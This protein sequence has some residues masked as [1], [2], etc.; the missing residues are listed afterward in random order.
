MRAGAVQLNSTDDAGA[1]LRAAETG[2]GPAAL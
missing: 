2:A 1:D